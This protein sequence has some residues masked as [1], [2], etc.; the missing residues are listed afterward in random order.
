MAAIRMGIMGFGLVGRQLYQHSLEHK[1]F[2]VVAISDIGRPEILHHLLST[3][4]GRD[5][6][7]RLERNHLISE[8]GQADP[9]TMMRSRVENFAPLCSRY[10]S[11]TVCG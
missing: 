4:M 9:P 6:D 1:R 2:D 7:V 10:A 5:V 8:R 3:T 11:T